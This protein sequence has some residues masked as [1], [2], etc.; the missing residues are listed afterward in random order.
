MELIN[1]LFKVSACSVLFFA[2][3]LLVLRKL[4]FFK[5]NRF[6]LL[7]SVLLSF[8]IPA[9]QITIDGEVTETVVVPVQTVDLGNAALP[10][11][12]ITELKPIPVVAF[13][14]FALL[15][16]LYASVVIALLLLAAWRIINLLRHTTTQVKEIN[17]LKLVVKQTG[18]T[19]CSFFNYVFI[20]ENSLSAEELQI[21][22][23][24]EE[25]HAK[26]YHSA[27]KLL[28]ILAKALLWFNPVIYLYDKA[29]EQ[30]HEYEA[31]EATSNNFGTELYA[32]LLL[33]LA[34]SKN[35]SP[36]IHNFVKSPIKQRI[37]MLFNSKSRNMKKLIYLLA[38]PIGMGLLWSFTIKINHRVKLIEQQET[39]TQQRESLIGKTLKGKVLNFEKLRLGEVINLKVGNTTV[40]VNSYN[41]KDKVKVGD[42]IT[43]TIGGLTMAPP[44]VVSTVTTDAKGNKSVS[45]DKT[46][47]LAS[48]VTGA[49]GV[50]IYELPHY[51]FLYEA[52]RARFAS[53]TIKSIEKSAKGT[54]NKIVLNDKHGFTINLNVAAQQFK[55][56]DFKKGDAILVKFIGEKLTGTKTYTTDK[57]I[58]LYSQPKKY[59]LI[60]KA[61]FDKFYNEN[62][63]QKVYN[64][65][66]QVQTLQDTR[67][68]YTPVKVYPKPVLETSSPA[69]INN[70][71]QIT[72]IKDGTMKIFDGELT[73]KEIEMHEGGSIVIAKNAKFKSEKGKLIESERMTFNTNNGSFTA[74]YP[75]RDAKPSAAY[76]LISK[77]KYSSTD[78]TVSNKMTGDLMLFGNAKVNVDGY[79]INGKLIS[80]NRY[81]NI[82]TAYL[83][84]ITTAN[85]M[86]LKGDKI[87]FDFNTKQVKLYD[88]AQVNL[89]RT[90]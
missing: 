48:K 50:I 83:G 6:Y 39:E 44:P 32:G 79:L 16:Y 82:I 75:A 40:A 53:S 45:I 42:E 19:N 27:D 37:K 4:T 5:F 22:L 76:E 71:T 74:T 57:M 55:T 12:V 36:L 59:E 89:P 28:L 13:D 73:A 23:Q 58:A 47:Y 63:R 43:V 9:T 11:A 65:L 61:L 46:S 51:A 87:E 29:L 25:V 81:S 85:K 70:K 21:L 68:T 18:F 86:E 8:V 10:N 52:N 30:T 72:Y 78:S 1:Y 33:R 56:N 2:F 67:G 69:L 54:I 17:G 15:P 80:V 49:N 88:K 26:Q 77:L 20:D 35:S 62:G 34:V 84:S 90:Y 64:K 41:F 60:N 14:W 3:Y 7:V 38:L 31:D 24:H 66:G